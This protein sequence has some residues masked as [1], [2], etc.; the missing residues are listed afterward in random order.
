M[1]HAAATESQDNPVIEAPHNRP[2]LLLCNG[3]RFRAFFLNPDLVSA[4]QLMVQQHSDATCPLELIEVTASTPA[5]LYS[6]VLRFAWPGF[7][8]ADIELVLQEYRQQRSQQIVYV[9]KA[10]ASTLPPPAP[11]QECVPAVFLDEERNRDTL[12]SIPPTAFLPSPSLP[13]Q[14]TEF[15]PLSTPLPGAAYSSSSSVHLLLQQIKAFLQCISTHWF[16]NHALLLP[17]LFLSI[18]LSAL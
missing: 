8:V 4:V 6:D 18:T 16:L 9:A 7:S 10:A 15:T 14:A 11:G 3:I 2:Y 12:G 1:P 5:V 13:P 17:I